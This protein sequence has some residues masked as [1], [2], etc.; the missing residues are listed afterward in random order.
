MVTSISDDELS[1][2]LFLLDGSASAF[3]ASFGFAPPL[4]LVA[5]DEDATQLMRVPQAGGTPT[6][7]LDRDDSAAR[8]A[9]RH[10]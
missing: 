10:G 4:S 2:G 7:G 1:Q 8:L 3:R 9:G 5:A 6:A